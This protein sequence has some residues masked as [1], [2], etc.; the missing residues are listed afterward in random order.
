MDVGAEKARIES[1][2]EA[3]NFHAA[4]NLAISALNACR[5]DGDQEGVEEFLAVIRELALAMEGVFGGG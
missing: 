1:F 2:A 5:R 4:F 3:G